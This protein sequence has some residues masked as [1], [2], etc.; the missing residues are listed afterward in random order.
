MSPNRDNTEWQH[1]RQAAKVTL[2]HRTAEGALRMELITHTG[3]YHD[4]VYPIEV[5]DHTT[6]HTGAVGGS[7]WVIK[8]F[9]PDSIW[10]GVM[11]LTSPKRVAIKKF[12]LILTDF[13]DELRAVVVPNTRRQKS[14]QLLV[15]YRPH[16]TIPV[17][18]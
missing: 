8:D 1:V 9:G 15:A 6:A 2:H 16:Q 17:S 5:V 7:M 12:V 13:V 3:R 4:L 10:T 14:F 11:A 18:A